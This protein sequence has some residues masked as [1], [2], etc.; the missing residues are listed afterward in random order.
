[1]SIVEFPQG[2]S[3]SLGIDAPLYGVSLRVTSPIFFCLGIHYMLFRD[4]F[5]FYLLFHGLDHVSPKEYSR[6]FFWELS[7]RET[8]GWTG[9]TL[10]CD[11]P[12]AQMHLGKGLS[13]FHGGGVTKD[14]LE[15]TTYG[16]WFHCSTNWTIPSLSWLLPRLPGFLVHMVIKGVTNRSLKGSGVS[17]F[18]KSRKILLLNHT[19][20]SRPCVDP[21]FN[22][23][24]KKTSFFFHWYWTPGLVFS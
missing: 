4:W 22:I 5:S 3:I 10:F 21:V 15:P 8:L 17:L 1:M 20:L 18:F 9:N 24:F 11:A 19:W 14:G 6:F 13:P 16:L 7:Y 2:K 12:L 23:N